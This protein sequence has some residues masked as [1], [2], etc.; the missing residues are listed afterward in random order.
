MQINLEDK[1]ISYALAKQEEDELKILVSHNLDRYFHPASLLKLFI[2]VMIED[3]TLSG[4]EK[5]STKYN[6]I[7]KAL[8]ASILDSDND[9]LAFLVDI[10]APSTNDYNFID[11]QELDDL[12]TQRQTISAYFHKLGFSDSLVLVNK[13]FGFDYYG[14]EEQILDKLGQNQISNNDLIKLLSLIEKS[15]PLTFEAM[16]RDLGDFER[17][18][19]GKAI[20]SSII[21][22]Q[23]YQV[24]AFT[25]AVLRKE[26]GL[27]AIYSKAGW[28]SKVR[29]DAVIFDYQS[30][31]YFLTVMTAELSMSPAALQGI[32]E[33]CLNDLLT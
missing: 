27:G 11:E 6:K 24:E 13:C 32:A 21:N 20:P 14:K 17:G 18:P 3:K 31:R 12:C 2:A 22:T 1:R 4:F 8:K 25:G 5:A 26:L 10:L 29:H 9:A 33:A 15:Y 16:H 7:L 19:E 30:A 23:D 28:T